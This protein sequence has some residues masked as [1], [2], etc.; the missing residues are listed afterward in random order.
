MGKNFSKINYNGV[1]EIFETKVK[2][3]T[4]REIDKWVCMKRDFSKA[5]RI[6]NRKFGLNLIIKERKIL[7]DQDLDWAR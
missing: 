3:G 7:E 2:D 5:L 6:I 1:E 4:G